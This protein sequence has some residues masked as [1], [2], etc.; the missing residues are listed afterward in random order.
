MSV[1]LVAE[2]FCIRRPKKAAEYRF[3]VKARNGEI[4][5]QSE[6]Y[7]EKRD[8]I[9]TARLLAPFVRIVEV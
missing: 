6:G 5:A 1:R 4:V 2:V 9:D 3:R 7:K 8:A